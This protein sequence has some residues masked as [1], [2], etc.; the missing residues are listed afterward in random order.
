MTNKPMLSVE[1][2]LLEEML[3]AMKETHSLPAK[4]YGS[5]LG[6]RVR[7]IL[8]SQNEQAEP[9][10]IGTLH[11]DCDERIVFESSGEIHIKD[12]M[13]V[14]SEPAAPV[15]S[16]SACTSCDGSGEYTDAIGDWRGYCTCPAGVEAEGIKGLMP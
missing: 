9:L 5:T 14:Y 13:Q 8:E 7:V 1:R 12:G 3:A 4:F 15:A 16:E 2:E 6:D 10:A 11:R